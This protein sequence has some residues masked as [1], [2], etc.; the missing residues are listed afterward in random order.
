MTRLVALLRGINVGGRNGVPMA[1]L[2]AICAGL[3]WDELETYIQ[4]GNVV[5]KAAGAAPALERALEQALETELN[6]KTDV[7][8]RSKAQWNRIMASNPF[9]SEAEAQANY[10]LCGIAKKALAGGAAAAVAEKAAAGERVREG[11]GVLW[12]HYPVGVG[13]SKLTTALIDRAAGSPVTGRNWRTM[14]KLQQ[15]LAP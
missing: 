10:V 4:S 2:K 7:L 1:K 11:G 12:F 8:I 5:F 14:V 6:V 3:G 9:A 13:R 15:M